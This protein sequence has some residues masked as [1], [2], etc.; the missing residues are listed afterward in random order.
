MEYILYLN[1]LNVSLYSKN[2][3]K[4]IIGLKY[5]NDKSIHTNWQPGQD[6]G[7]L[8]DECTKLLRQSVADLVP[9]PACADFLN[10]N[11]T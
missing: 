10:K 6:L 7:F 8:S 1:F 3:E 11:K 9:D 4:F 2:F 5:L